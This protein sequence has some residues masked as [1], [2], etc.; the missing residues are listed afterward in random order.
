M[1]Q[2]LAQFADKTAMASGMNARGMRRSRR[3]ACKAKVQLSWLAD[4]GVPNSTFGECKDISQEGMQVVVPAG[5]PVRTAV[6]FMISGSPLQGSGTV[7]SCTR[8]ASKF[9]VGVTFAVQL[10]MDPA[11][12]PIPGIEII[13]V[14]GGAQG[15]AANA[16]K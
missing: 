15:P 2:K 9:T 13:E 5:V 11:T 6:Q 1:L 16:T 8:N 12:T 3:V 14:F 4:N 10:R 7:R